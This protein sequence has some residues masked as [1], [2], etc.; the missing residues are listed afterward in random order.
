M[1]PS[2]RFA[3]SGLWVEFRAAFPGKE[4]TARFI[5]PSGAP[6]SNSESAFAYLRMGRM[7]ASI[8]DE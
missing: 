7:V 5:F 3:H 1:F 8:Q 6:K 4:M 2:G